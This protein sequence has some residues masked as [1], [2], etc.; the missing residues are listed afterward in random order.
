MTN[1]LAYWAYLLQGGG[2]APSFGQKP[3]CRQTFGRTTQAQR[4]RGMLANLL[5]HGYV[6]KTLAQPNVSRPD[7]F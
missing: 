3:F 1:T 2:S 4:Q 7:G 6:D 5:F